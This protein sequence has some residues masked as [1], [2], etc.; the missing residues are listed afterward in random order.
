MRRTRKPSFADLG[1]ELDHRLGNLLGELG[2]ALSEAMGRLGDGGDG[3][4]LRERNFETPG[5]PIRAGIRV[6]VGGLA[7][8]RAMTPDGDRSRKPERGPAGTPSTGAGHGG[9]ARPRRTRDRPTGNDTDSAR[10][11]EA[12]IM[13][14]G[15]RWTLVADLPGCS[16]ADVALSDTGPGGRLHVT[17][18]GRGRRYTGSFDLPAGLSAEGL[19]KS[20]VNGVLELSGEAPD[21]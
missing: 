7:G 20:L 11:I 19:S 9:R 10:Q 1:E 6:R 15:G 17:A 14:S 12:S 13:V 4:L 16:D 3:E 18:S 2:E 21:R 8:D 5:G